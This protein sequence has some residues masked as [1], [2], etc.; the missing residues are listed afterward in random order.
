MY[1]SIAWNNH[2][3]SIQIIEGRK[4]KELL[5]ILLKQLECYM[6]RKQKEP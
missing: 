5:F 4:T 1:S 6:A 2:S 3:L